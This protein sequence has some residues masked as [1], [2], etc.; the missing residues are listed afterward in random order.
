MEPLL[1]KIMQFNVRNFSPNDI[2]DIEGSRRPIARTPVKLIELHGFRTFENL[3]RGHVYD[4][5]RG[6][7]FGNIDFGIDQFNV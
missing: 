7:Q 4:R 5:D 2:D 1:P 6:F 3:K